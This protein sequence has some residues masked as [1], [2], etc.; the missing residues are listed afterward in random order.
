[1][2]AFS[3]ELCPFS[4][5]ECYLFCFV[6]A[7]ASFFLV[8]AALSPASCGFLTPQAV[9]ILSIATQFS[10]RLRP[11]DGSHRGS[12]QVSTLQDELKL[13]DVGHLA[14]PGPFYPKSGRSLY[15]L[16][17]RASNLH[18]LVIRV[19][20]ISDIFLLSSLPPCR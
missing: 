1:M 4:W 18:W 13:L 14:C 3:G 20:T 2:G 15:P 9:Y 10:S 12:S 6:F 19:L 7:N 17:T 11:L 8:S 16:E 5:N